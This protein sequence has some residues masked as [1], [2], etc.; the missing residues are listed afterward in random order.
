[1][2]TKKRKLLLICSAGGHFLELYLLKELWEK[3]DRVWITLPGKDTEYLLAKE[4]KVL[5]HSP[6]IRNVKNLISNFFF[7]YATIRKE[8]PDAIISTG[9]AIGVP[10]IF[11]GKMFKIKTIFIEL[12]TRV[13]SLSISGK[14]IYPFS[15]HFL[16]QWPELADK[17]KKAVY[18]GRIYDLCDG[19]IRK[20]LL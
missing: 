8:K 14:L 6:T 12:L 7:A 3:Y 19:R 20:I 9:A 2:N 1:M 18:V 10:F 13:T 5:G 4:S 16:V 17:Y 11:L 15:S